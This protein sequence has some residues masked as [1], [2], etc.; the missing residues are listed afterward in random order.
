M[1]NHVRSECA[2][3]S[4]GRLFTGGGVVRDEAA[5]SRP[6]VWVDDDGEDNLPDMSAKK[7]KA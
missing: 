7:Q 3:L 1:C 5:E 4:A 6:S 2:P